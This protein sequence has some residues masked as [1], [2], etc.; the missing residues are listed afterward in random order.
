MRFRYL[1][2]PLFLGCLILYFVNR[3][4]VKRYLPNAFSQDY[5]NDVICIPFWVPIMLFIM[6]K[7]R[8]RGDDC[9]P[10]G[11]EI[12]IPLIVW[13]FVFECYLPTVPFFKHLATPDYRDI[14]C[15]TAGGILAALFWQILYREKIPSKISE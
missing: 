15:Y 9:A 2:D 11:S 7:T 14:V 1:K 5:L 8:L 12:L 13:S 3:W 6:R 4:F 10:R